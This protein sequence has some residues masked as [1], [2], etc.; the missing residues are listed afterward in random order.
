VLAF[1]AALLGGQA[2]AQEDTQ[3]SV[4]AHFEGEVIPLRTNASTVGGFLDELSICLPDTAAIQPPQDSALMDGMSVFL[5]GLTVTRLTTEE[6]IPVEMSLEQNT[7]I[8]PEGMA[9]TDP[10]RAGRREVSYTIFYYDGREVGRR[11]RAKVIEPMTPTRAVFFTQHYEGDGPTI[12]QILEMRLKPSD[13]H[14][15]PMRYREIVTMESTAYEPGPRSCGRFASGN[16]SAGY[17]AGYGVVAVDPKVI[18]MHTRLYISGYGYAV[19]GD[20]GSAIKGNR[21]DLG[22]L[23]VDECIQYG[24]RDVEVYILY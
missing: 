3:K 9:I 22:F 15:P 1:A 13:L 19:A 4:N 16:T 20:V 7:H 5:K 18:P 21:I 8:G 17:K 11:R 23:T 2:I 6:I 24:R 10:G 12:E 14:V